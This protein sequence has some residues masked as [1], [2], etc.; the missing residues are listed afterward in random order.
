MTPAQRD[1][2]PVWLRRARD[3]RGVLRRRQSAYLRLWLGRA[4]V[5]GGAAAVG[6]L[7]VLFARL[8]ESLG[9]AFMLG[10][11]EHRWLPVLL[12]PAG[13]A[14]IVTLTRRFFPGAEGSG[15]PQAVAAQA[16]AQRGLPTRWLSLR[17]LA[18]KIGLGAAAIGC[19][20]SMGREGPS[21][22]VGASLMHALHRWL[23]RALH[24]RRAHLIVAG[25]AAGVAAAFNTPLAGIVFAIEE[26]S[27]RVESRLSGL[28]ITAIVLAG[29]MSQVFLGGGHY[30]GRVVIGA[31]QRDLLTSVAAAALIC[32]VAGGLFARMLIH[33]AFHWRGRLAD[34][35]RDHPAVF[36]AGCGL[37][38]A[39]LGVTC[40]NAVFG[41][42]YAQTRAL[43]EGQE[44]LPAHFGLFKFLA[45]LFSYLAG[46]PGG[47]FAPSLAI[48]AGIGH[49]IDPLF[50]SA[51]A[52]GMLLVLCMAG[53]LAA[54]TQSP[55]TA[56]VIVMEMVDGYSQVIGLMSVSLLAA[57][58]S[59][60]FSPPLYATLAL[61]YAPPPPAAGPA[62]PGTDRQGEGRS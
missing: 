46:L 44:H 5:W 50:A 41:T 26:M 54:A 32:G 59:R 53:F 28:V 20:F 52:S 31:S 8:S 33:S 24:V 48:G 51:P 7:A 57:A 58:V 16:E 36:A 49:A 39:A 47:I 45:T 11:A 38:I 40:G 4:L 15:I 18:G 6:M 30:F 19:G 22:Q 2:R 13:G 21:V 34:W 43:L 35:R 14:L 62:P 23:P 10:A 56:F 27:R 42:G 55:I 3:P 1:L 29:V 37:L 25:G 61:R 12:L 17:I 9:H 60:F